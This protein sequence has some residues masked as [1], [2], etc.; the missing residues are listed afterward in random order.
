MTNPTP[1]SIIIVGSGVFGLSTAYALSQRSLYTNT[2][3]TVLDRSPFPSPDGSS[4]DTSRIVRTDYSDPAYASLASA[5]QAEWRK[6]GPSDLGGE[7]RYTE[8]G[9]VLVADKGV[10]GEEYVKKSWENVRKLME[11]AGDENALRELGSRELIEKE[12]GTGGGAGDWG[13]LNRRSGW[14]DAE[15]GMRWLRRQVEATGKVEFVLAQVEALLREEKKVIG[16]SLKGGKEI[17]AD[18]TVC[19]SQTIGHSSPRKKPPADRI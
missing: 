10:Q 2:Q 3:I 19:P 14:A 18:L 1:K 9:V 12:V 13:Y 17:R 16:V 8:S 7:G 5:A 15:A 4:I 6:Q 11:K